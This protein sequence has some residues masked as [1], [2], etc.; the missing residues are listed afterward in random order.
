M[1]RNDFKF[2]ERDSWDHRSWCC[3]SEHGFSCS[4]VFDLR[5]MNFYTIKIRLIKLSK[6]GKLLGDEDKII[7]DSDES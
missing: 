3:M 2:P 1:K 6:A 5:W 7:G 4:E